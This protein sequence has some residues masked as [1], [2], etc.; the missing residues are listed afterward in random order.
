LQYQSFSSYGF[1][2]GIFNQVIWNSLHGR[3][4][5][6]SVMIDSPSFFGH[7]FSP[8][9]LAF[10]PLYALRSSPDTLLIIQTIALASAALPIYWFARKELGN[11]QAVA[12]CAAY[13]LFPSLQYVNLFEFHEIALATPLLAFAAYFLLRRRNVPFIVCSILALLTK[14][15][16]GLIVAGF[17][18]FI[19]FFRREHMFGTALFFVGIGWSAAA[20]QY[21]IPHFLGAPYASNAFVIDRYRYLGDS[22]SEILWTAVTRPGLV[23]QHLFVPAKIEFVMQLLV[24]LVFFPLIGGEVFALTIPSIGYLLLGDSPSQ[25]SIRY[26]YTAPLLPFVFFAA[27]IGMRR[28]MSWRYAGGAFVFRGSLLAS[29]IVVASLANYFFQSPGPFALQFDAERYRVTPHAL[30]GAQLMRQIPPGASVMTEMNFIPYLTH[31]RFA[32]YA[33]HVLDLRQIEYLFADKTL[34]IHDAYQVIW[35]DVL[36][37]PYFETLAAQDGYILKKRARGTFA[38]P[39]QFQ[40]DRRITL[41]GYTL[42]SSTPARRGE[43][44]HLVLVWRA[45]EIIRERFVVYV[46]LADAVGKIHSQGDREPANGWLST[47]RWNVGDVTPDGYTLELDPDMPAG[48]YRI[49]TGLYKVDGQQ[50][51]TAVDSS[52]KPLGDEVTVT[53]VQIS[54]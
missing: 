15:E 10:V 14:E 12:V 20:L 21:I 7:H 46:H 39:L 47:D 54:R 26:Q 44:I 4:F 19:F 6:N 49:T 16:V 37:T 31:T 1:D 52:G 25:N 35:N 53:T 43:T 9:L 2:L 17:G 45:D 50:R 32:Y 30:L 29:V 11:G 13:F 38:H 42:E 51:L 5:E 28:L 41:L 22:V 8:I 33:Q 40:F 23:L 48:E 24:P 3:L 18:V 36:D 34:A 27:V